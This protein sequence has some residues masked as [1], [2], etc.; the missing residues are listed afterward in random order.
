MDQLERAIIASSDPGQSNEVRQQAAL[1]INNF[2]LLPNG[3][4]ACLEKVFAPYSPERTVITFFCFEALRNLSLH[5]YDSLSIEDRQLLKTQ[6]FRWLFDYAPS[7]QHVEIAIRKKFCQVLVAVFSIE[8][9]ENWSD[10]FAVILLILEKKPI[11]PIQVELLLRIINY[12]DEL[13]ISLEYTCAPADIARSNKIKDSMREGSVVKIADAWYWLLSQSN[14]HPELGNLALKNIQRYVGWIDIRLIV[15]QPYLTLFDQLLKVPGLREGACLCLEQIAAKGMDARSKQSMLIELKFH[16][17]VGSVSPEDDDEFT[18]AMARLVNVVGMESI[19]CR[20]DAYKTKASSEVI[21]SAEQLVETSI[22]IALRFMANSDDGISER[23][24]TFIGLYLYKLRHSKGLPDKVVGYLRN[25]LEIIYHKMKF[26]SS[27]NFEREEE[28]EAEFLKYRKELEKIFRNIARLIPVQT[29]EFVTTLMKQ[30]LTQDCSRLPMA[31]IES[32]LRLFY[33]M[34]EGLSDQEFASNLQALQQAMTIIM[35]SNVTAHTHQAIPIVTFDVVVRY[36]AAIPKTPENFH[37]VLMAFLDKRGI[38]HPNPLV[39]GRATYQFLKL[40]RALV[41]DFKPFAADL[42][43]SLLSL[44]EVKLVE[45]EQALY[46]TDQQHLYEVAGILTY[47]LRTDTELHKTCI[48]RVIS[49]LINNIHEILSKKLFQNDSPENPQ[50]SSYLV[51]AMSAI[52]MFSKGFKQSTPES[53]IPFKTTLELEIQALRLLPMNEDVRFKVTFFL[54]RMI[55]CMQKD[56]FPFL[57]SALDQMI[58]NNPNA[59]SI[60]AMIRLINQLMTRFKT[61]VLAL[62]DVL[63]LQVVRH[64]FTLYSQLDDSSEQRELQRFYFLFIQ[65]ILLSQL[66]DVFFTERNRNDLQAILE[67]II[68][69]C[70]GPSAVLDLKNMKVC[71]TILSEI[72]VQWPGKVDFFPQLVPGVVEACFSVIASPSFD[73]AEGESIQV[74][75]TIVKTLKSV[76]RTPNFSNVALQILQKIPGIDA[77]MATT[78]LQQLSQSSGTAFV[79]FFKDLIIHVRSARQ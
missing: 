14:Q 66:G 22:V 72:C 27:Y 35:D 75:V 76:S 47:E 62:I 32:C 60:A 6:L 5:S 31:D 43:N 15:N 70:C 17:L 2:P 54:H 45:S 19:K 41:E 67:T 39:R 56:I 68:R 36:A 74:L 63:L 26:D 61:D 13:V 38:R 7:Q 49:Q 12:I 23:V 78:F 16:Q 11:I 34:G 64:V 30:I 33:V 1:F 20:S 57:P 50:F 73:L 51:R 18:Y 59:Q 71:F 25:L 9:P 55:E 65:T 8:Y 3:W 28:L 53:L 29:F 4:K 40:V 48:E 10:F 42:I 79:K 46:D 77:N 58:G 37:M 52:G 21:L 69:G 44:L 24:F